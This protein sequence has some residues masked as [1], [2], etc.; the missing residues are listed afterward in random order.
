MNLQEFI[1]ETLVQ[2]SQGITAANADLKDTGAKVNPR[3]VHP[4]LHTSDKV[5]G[6]VDTSKPKEEFFP[7]VE[8]VEFDVAL[9]VSEGKETK[10]G[11]GIAIGTIGLGSQ[12]R[13]DS[14]RSSESRVKFRIPVQLPNA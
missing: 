3:N 10:G 11:I 4:Y 7:L 12:G 9:T 6:H 5:Y 8:L 13:S 2:I 1:R 14:E